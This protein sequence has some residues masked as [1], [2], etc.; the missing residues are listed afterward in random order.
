VSKKLKFASLAVGLTAVVIFGAMVAA[1]TY[2]RALA[3]GKTVREGVATV[4][5]TKD[6]T[7]E[8]AKHDSLEEID[9]TRPCPPEERVYRLYLRIDEFRSLSSDDNEFLLRAERRNETKG[10]SRCR[11]LRYYVAQDSQPVAGQQVEFQFQFFDSFLGSKPSALI[12]LGL[13]KSST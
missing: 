8:E 1:D 2:Y 5:A 10:I 13:C 7:C 4:L 9:K 11:D 3:S 6:L 12:F